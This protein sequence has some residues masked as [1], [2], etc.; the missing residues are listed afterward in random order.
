MRLPLLS[1]VSFHHKWDLGSSKWGQ[2]LIIST[3]QV[4]GTLVEES[5]NQA[6][7]VFVGLKMRD[8]GTQ[9]EH[10]DACM[11]DISSTTDAIHIELRFWHLDRRIWWMKYELWNTKCYV[12]VWR[13]RQTTRRMRWLIHYSLW[14]CHVLRPSQ[15]LMS[16]PSI[17]KSV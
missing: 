11:A 8:A 17:E 14:W 15:I 13:P 9:Q 6:A 10:H 16:L 3:N 1:E 7:A 2:S 12:C 4:I 5:I